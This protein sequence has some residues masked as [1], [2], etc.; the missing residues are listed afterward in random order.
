VTT[1]SRP[2]VDLQFYKDPRS[3][4][5]GT[6][7]VVGHTARFKRV[8]TTRREPLD[9]GN[10]G[11]CVG[12]CNAGVLAAKPLAYAVQNS[13]G[14]KI[15][16]AAKA[17]DE[18]QGRYFSEGATM[19]AGL[20][21]CRKANYYRTFGW[22]FGI[23]DTINWLVRRGP[24]ALGINWYESMYETDSKGLIVV[25]GPIAGGHAILA[26]GFWPNHPEFGDVLVLTNSWGSGW[27]ING[28]GYLPVESA[29]RLLAEDGESA[30]IVEFPVRPI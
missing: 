7:S 13:T 6:R 12:F 9:Q 15:F 11:E 19:I 8:W 10:E 14:R 28:R 25:D 29:K 24:V 16:A 26:N 5:Y 21:V 2:I 20:Q 23:D 3:R 4:D 30:A 18:S 1:P 27:G 22:N 17:F